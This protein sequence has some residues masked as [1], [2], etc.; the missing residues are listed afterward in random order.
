MAVRHRKFCRPPR[1]WQLLP[2]LAL[3]HLRQ[4]SAPDL[5][6]LPDQLCPSPLASVV[7]GT[8]LRDAALGRRIAQIHFFIV[9]MHSFNQVSV[10]VGSTMRCTA[11]ALDSASRPKAVVDLARAVAKVTKEEGVR[12]STSLAVCMRLLGRA[13]YMMT[14]S[15]ILLVWLALPLARRV[16][17]KGL[18][19]SLQLELVMVSARFSCC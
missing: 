17:L 8:Q 6:T 14:P 11:Q 12:D 18:P 5:R 7:S 9:A 16:L 1:Q 13:S 19:K 3:K 4:P 10:K 2:T 15:V